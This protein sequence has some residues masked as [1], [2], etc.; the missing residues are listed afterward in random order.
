M[1]E[2][3]FIIGGARSGKSAYA[4]RLAQALPGPVVFIATAQALD[5][6]MRTRIAEHRSRRPPEWMTLQLPGG[7]GEHALAQVKQAGVVVLDC[8]TLLISNAMLQASP[9]VDHPDEQAARS[10]VNQEV[11]SLLRAVRQSST[12]WII[13]SNEVGQ[14]VVPPYPAGRQFRDLLGWANMEVARQAKEVVWMVAGIP[15]PIG[16]HR[17]NGDDRMAFSRG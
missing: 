2:I 4:Q 11:E 16:Q 12:P 8:L 13:V 10:M 6:E 9:D 1:H 17:L 15:V 3:T 7:I 14:G 5:G